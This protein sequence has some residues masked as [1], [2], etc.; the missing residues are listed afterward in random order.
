MLQG[1]RKLF[2]GGGKVRGGGGLFSKSHIWNSFFGNTILGMQV[3]YMR[4]HIPLDTIRVICNF[5]F[6]NRKSQS[7]EKLAK[8]I[9]RF[10]IQFHS[11]NLTHFTNLK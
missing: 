5:K 8:K 6:S 2:Y 1:H 4:P 9:T 11:K 7:R 3:F 10:T